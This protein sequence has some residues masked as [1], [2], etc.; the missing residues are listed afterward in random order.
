MRAL[1]IGFSL[2][3]KSWYGPMIPENSSSEKAVA[4]ADLANTTV[5]GR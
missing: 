3:S 1:D 4:S 2:L 5:R